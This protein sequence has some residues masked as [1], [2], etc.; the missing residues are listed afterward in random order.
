M[1]AAFV[2][3]L[4]GFKREV[5]KFC[6]HAES[7]KWTTEALE[8]GWRSVLLHY[9]N[10]NGDDADRAI[11]VTYLEYGNRRLIQLTI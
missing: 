2:C 3:D 11:A 10:M 1:S 9:F 8:A 4:D 7:G 6:R 5:A